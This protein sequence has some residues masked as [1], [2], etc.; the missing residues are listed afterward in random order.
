MSNNKIKLHS[1]DK[2]ENDFLSWLNEIDWTVNRAKEVDKEYK[3]KS[4]E[5]IY[6]NLLKEQLIKLNDFI[7]EHNVEDLISSLKRDLKG[8]N[9]M[10][11][12]RSFYRLLRNGKNFT[13]TKEDGKSEGKFVQLID[14]S[15]PFRNSLIAVNQF[16]VRKG[17][18]VIPDVVLI[19]NGI[20][21]VIIELK[22][23]AQGKDYFDALEDLIKYE[24][25]APDL[26]VPVLF[27]IGADSENLRMG[28]IGAD[29][30]AYMPWR[31]FSK[32]YQGGSETKQAVKSILNPKT[33]LD[34][35]HNFVFYE[36]EIGGDIKII[37]RYMQYYAT[38]SILNRIKKGDKKKGLVWH[39]QGS[40][41]SYTMLYTAINLLTSQILDNPQILLIVDKDKLRQ[42][43]SDNLHNIGFERPFHIASSINDL[44]KQIREGTSQLILTTIQMFQ[45][46]KKDVQTNPNTVILTDE[47]HRFMEQDLGTKLISA[48]PNN[49]H[50]G[51]TGTPVR[52]RERDT[53]R[54]YCP[55]DEL[56]L[57]KYSLKNGLDDEVII[58]VY[59]QPR[60]EMKWEYDGSL[61]DKGF[62]KIVGDLPMEERDKRIRECLTKTDLAEL[63]PRVTRVVKE[64]VEHYSDVEKNN[65][66]GMVV[67]PSQ[68]AAALFGE[69][70]LKY[71]N[72][73]EIK[74]LISGTGSDMEP[75]MNKFYTTPEERKKIVK[76]F[77]KE[78]KN[79]KIVV[80]CNMLLTG[81]NSPL[82]KVIYLDRYLMNH[83]LLQA[84]A[85]TNRPSEGKNNGEIVDFQGSF[86]NIDEALDYDKI[87]K[88]HAAVNR[89]KLIDD[90]DQI[91]RELLAIFKDIEKSGDSSSLHECI[92]LLS[93][94]DKI[95]KNFEKKFKLLRD[96]YE[97]IPPD[98]R[99]T[100][101]QRMK[102][103]AWLTQVY[104]AFIR[105]Y[106]RRERATKEL[107]A[108][109]KELLEKNVNIIE[110]NKEFPIF[111]VSSEH[112]EKIKNMKAPARAAEIAHTATKSTND[113]RNQNLLFD[114]LSKRLNILIDN[115]KKGAISDEEAADKLEEVEK[116]IINI[117]K[118]PEKKGLTPG[119][120]AIYELVKE[121][122]KKH[123]K[124]D[125]DAKEIA[126]A[127]GKR[128]KEDVD[129]TYVNWWK[130]PEV[131]RKCRRSIINALI[132]DMGKKGLYHAEGFIEKAQEYLI[133]NARTEDEQD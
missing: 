60:H 64:I 129:T 77:K 66:K 98:P 9:L 16:R 105:H 133:E 81:F 53:F 41:K 130:N 86:E 39:T 117:E 93:K 88:E 94:N 123:I 85:R 29:E 89:D 83:N 61:I 97:S 114:K 52:E 92:S 46:V 42:Q 69:E 58:P 43:M 17:K 1:E 87:T 47:A 54:H 71:R 57:H 27:N 25:G 116:K 40:G 107:R 67:T 59:F 126:K 45:D 7:N 90:F 84:I 31:E 100:K 106:Y 82:L 70:L 110:I 21:L 24:K 49:F 104:I 38:H 120:Y 68:K 26:F 13:V 109:T 65:W 121:D 111:K 132:K 124:K 18:L 36:K 15:E 48:I 33:L 55:E 63:R 95:R 101:K 80:V 128:F 44:Q 119:E 78:D 37:P 20:P 28:G 91:L 50:F 62:D 11:L 96:I 75:F 4:N 56:Y 12:N 8:D 108:K 113:K 122:Y 74:V 125:E 14:F 2:F 99:M 19:V 23:L 131:E 22:S 79:P 127:I 30:S 5:I 76:N 118:E 32:E 10:S 34:I 115:W 6:W 112:L 35:L 102:S 3:R 72:P 51:F 103:Y 73:E